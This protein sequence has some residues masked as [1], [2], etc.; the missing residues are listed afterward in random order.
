MA[1]SP[2]RL[3]IYLYS[4]HRAVIFATAQLSCILFCHGSVSVAFPML[5]QNL[6][7]LADGESSFAPEVAITADVKLL[8][9]RRLQQEH[10]MT[11]IISRNETVNLVRQ[12]LK[13]HRFK[14]N[15]VTDLLL[16]LVKPKDSNSSNR[17]RFRPTE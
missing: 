10:D 8:H 7:R 9:R 2:Q 5:S 17:P 1:I 4:A 15:I 6:R 13:V 3:T 16:N 11:E 12:L 14:D